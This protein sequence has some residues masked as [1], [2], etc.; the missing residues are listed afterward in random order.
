MKPAVLALAL[1]ACGPQSAAWLR[2]EAPLRVPQDCDAVELTATR[3]SD[4]QLIYQSH[5]ALGSGPPFP[6]EL[7]L[8]TDDRRNLGRESVEL[9]VRALK[10]LELAAPWSSRTLRFDLVAHQWSDVTV[11]VCDCP[12]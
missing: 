1:C 10:G 11:E 12:P 9:T 4:A 7:A 2:I 8:V 6:L 5:H 3:V